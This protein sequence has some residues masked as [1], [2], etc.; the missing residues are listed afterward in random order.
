MRRVLG[1]RTECRQCHPR[2]HVRFRQPETV[3]HARQSGVGGLMPQATTV[4]VARVQLA[5]SFQTSLQLAVSM[6]LGLGPI[7]SFELEAGEPRM[8]S[9]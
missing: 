2:A 3:I 6:R 4:L 7:R 5:I 8:D 9:P 1:G